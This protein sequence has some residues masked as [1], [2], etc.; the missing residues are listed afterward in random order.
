MQCF[1]KTGSTKRMGRWSSKTTEEVASEE[2]YLCCEGL[3]L[4]GERAWAGVERS[5]WALSRGWAMEG[6]A[7][8]SV[9]RRGREQTTF[10]YFILFGSL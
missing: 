9:L 10:I 2:V 8:K 5:V 4:R 3:G 6:R 7:H 1:G